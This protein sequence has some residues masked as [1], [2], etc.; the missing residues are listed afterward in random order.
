MHQYT[1][2]VM[3]IQH[4]A[5]CFV[6][7]SLWSHPMYRQCQESIRTTTTESGNA[8]IMLSMSS[9]N[10]QVRHHRCICIELANC[11]A[12]AFADALDNDATSDLCARDARRNVPCLTFHVVVNFLTGPHQQRSG[13]KVIGWWDLWLV[14]C[15]HVN[16][17]HWRRKHRFVGSCNHLHVEATTNGH[18]ESD[19][20][21]V[22]W[23]NQEWYGD[24]GRR[25]WAQWMLDISLSLSLSACIYTYSHN[26]LHSVGFSSN[27]LPMSSN[28]QTSLAISVQ[29]K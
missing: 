4:N 22:Q 9:V 7:T 1:I 29:H 17:R 3:S 13:H 18:I 25:A 12:L 10:V 21:H 16:L 6:W 5:T 27:G 23:P 14:Q 28:T 19:L 2:C 15:E 8:P 24:S 11:L 20:R 26:L